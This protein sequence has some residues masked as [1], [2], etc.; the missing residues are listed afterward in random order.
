MEM[1]P[2]IAAVAAAV[3][4]VIL[5][6]KLFTA[7]LKL[8]L[9]LALNTLIGFAALIVVNALGSVIGVSIGINWINA[10]V[11]GLLGLPGVGVLLILQWLL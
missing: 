8:V 2:T 5:L 4:L 6:L 10:L 9:K 7:P 3:L 11:V 1:L